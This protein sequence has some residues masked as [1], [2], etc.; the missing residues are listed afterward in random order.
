MKIWVSKVKLD[1]IPKK[2]KKVYLQLVPDKDSCIKHLEELR[3]NGD[4]CN[5]NFKGL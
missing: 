2:F 5:I 4:V 3:W 1:M